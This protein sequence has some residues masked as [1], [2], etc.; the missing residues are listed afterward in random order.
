MVLDSSPDPGL[1]ASS[2]ACRLHILAASAAEL[3]ERLQADRSV[4]WDLQLPRSGSVRLSGRTL[5]P[6]AGGS[7]QVE[8]HDTGEGCR[9]H[10]RLLAEGPPSSPTATVLPACL[11]RLIEAQGE[12]LRPPDLGYGTAV[13]VPG[14]DIPDIVDLLLHPDRDYPVV[15]VTPE[16]ASGAPSVDPDALARALIGIAEVQLVLTPRGCRLLARTLH[17]RGASERHGVYDG[18]LRLYRPG[19][20]VEDPLTRH[21]LLLRQG[22]QRRPEEERLPSLARWIARALAEEAVTPGRSAGI[23]R[24]GIGEAKTSEPPG[25]EPPAVEPPG[26]EEPGVE[27]P[28]APAP[29]RAEVDGRSDEVERLQAEADELRRDNDLLRALL[30]QADQEV[31]EAT[32]RAEEAERARRKAETERDRAV[33]EREAA[34]N[35]GTVLDALE[36]ARRLFGDRLVVFNGVVKQAEASLYHRPEDAFRVLAILAL[37]RDDGEVQAGLKRHFSERQARWR[38]SDSPATERAFPRRFL[39][40]DGRVSTSTRHIT[41]GGTERPDRHMQ[42][43]YDWLP[44]DRI[45]LLHMGHH[46][47]TVAV[48]T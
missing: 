19:M 40:P 34:W 14:E 23:G 7:L 29:P 16:N 17:E 44:G 45:G 38:G 11:V 15:L 39:G 25:V 9:L 41:L 3:A 35:L 2:A 43:Y 1:A 46:L 28:A 31:R 12:R 21:P 48:D 33:R 30:D 18:A 4:R 10:A 8:L 27:E 5:P 37:A 26:V 6:E 36:A 47:K 13:E 22:F 42:I 32:D 24:T 20:R